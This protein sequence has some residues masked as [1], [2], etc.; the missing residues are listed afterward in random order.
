MNS[1]KLIAVVFATL[2]MLGCTTYSQKNVSEASA[3]LQRGKSVAIAMPTNG[4]Y[5]STVY[6]GSGHMTATPVQGA[7]SRHTNRTTAV[8]NC[9]DLNCLMTD[10]SQISDYYVVP[11]ILHWE[12]RATEWSGIPDKIEVKITV[13]DG[14]TGN[15]IALTIIS[16]KSKWLTLGGDKPQDLLPEPLNAYVESLY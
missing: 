5:G 11:E 1:V 16:G 12:D 10:R 14:L 3:K 7:F 2:S 8:A 4:Q 6:S 9:K 13:F 15:D